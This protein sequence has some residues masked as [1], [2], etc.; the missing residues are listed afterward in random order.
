MFLAV[1]IKWNNLTVNGGDVRFAREISTYRSVLSGTG[2]KLTLEQTLRH[3]G[4][5]VQ[6]GGTLIVDLGRLNGAAALSG[7]GKSRSDG[8][9]RPTSGYRN[10]TLRALSV[11]RP[12]EISTMWQQ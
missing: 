4:A 3:T 7:E 5:F 8:R 2:T 10:T 11:R 6:S 12:L 1:K 9:A